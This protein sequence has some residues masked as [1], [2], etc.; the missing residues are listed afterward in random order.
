MQSV[1]VFI[2]VPTVRDGDSKFT[3]AISQILNMWGVNVSD[4]LMKFKPWRQKD[5]DHTHSN[6]AFLRQ[7]GMTSLLFLE[8]LIVELHV[9]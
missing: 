6:I 1:S 2:I 7:F 3:K 8:V 9:D 4:P 5:I